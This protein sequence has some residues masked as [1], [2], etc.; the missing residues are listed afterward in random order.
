[1]HG[2]SIICE[3]D[4]PPGNARAVFVLMNEN[5][6]TRLAVQKKNPKRINV[7]LDNNF[8]FG[9]YRE[10]AAWLEI[11][12]KLS[13][14]KIAELLA[15][16]QERDAMQKA[17]EYISYKPRTTMETRKK[18]QNAGFD[19]LLIEKTVS[20][21]TQ[22]GLLND[23]D[24]AN[25][26]VEE[27]SRIKPR[28]RRMLIYELRLKGISDDLIQS[29]VGDVDD[30]RSAYEI[31]EKRLYRYENLEK[32][33]FRKKLGNYLAGKGFSYDVISETTQKIWKRM[34]SSMNRN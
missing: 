16:D 32:L 9:L 28:S 10:T 31:A 15:A 20:Q 4:K 7:Y 2:E 26:W 23:E 19:D 29:A 22:H 21:L 3:Y 14:E 5:K 27:R 11:G 12:Q 34:H 30:F 18:L 8:A 33:D 25:R 13:E 1:M 24:Y 17:I 6:I